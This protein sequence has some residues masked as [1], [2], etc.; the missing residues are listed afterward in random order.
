MKAKN[1]PFPK[2]SLLT[3]VKVSLGIALSIIF[4]L[5]VF[6][7]FG[8]SSFRHD[9]KYWILSGYGG[10]VFVTS[11]LFYCVTNLLITDKVKDRWSILSETVFV[12]TSFLFCLL[13]CYLYWSVL[14]QASF[15]ASIFFSFIRSA[16]YVAVFPMVVYYLFLYFAYRDMRYAD[17]IELKAQE[18][19]ANQVVIKSA[20]QNEVI[21]TTYDDLLCIKS[22]D[23][24]V[25]VYSLNEGKSTRAM[26]RN[27]LKNVSAQ[28]NSQYVVQ[29][30]RSYLINKSK[31]V[32]IQGNVTNAKAR[33][34]G[35]IGTIPVSR[36]YVKSLREIV[37]S[38]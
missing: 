33:L 28:L 11:I 27:T 15:D 21:K 5:T 25:I 30:H 14:F 8:T 10:V 12:F 37:V 35:G 38:S 18:V 1:I 32:E 16:F 23:N 31:I 20:N 26:I 34:E 22:N 29:C 13:A 17:D 24:Y 36:S 6:E 19:V 3:F 9:Y 7:P 2:A 4:I